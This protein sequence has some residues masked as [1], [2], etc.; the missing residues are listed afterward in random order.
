MCATHLHVYPTV[1]SLALETERAVA[2]EILLAV[3]VNLA[4]RLVPTGLALAQGVGLAVRAGETLL[5]LAAVA[6]T[7]LGLQYADPVIATHL[8]PAHL[9]STVQHS[10]K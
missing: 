8:A 10:D 7:G 5:A 1:A 2:E 6:R 3:A 4:A 9:V